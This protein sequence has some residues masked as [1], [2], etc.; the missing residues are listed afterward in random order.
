MKKLGRR[1]QKKKPLSQRGGEESRCQHSTMKDA[2]VHATLRIKE[3]EKQRAQELEALCWMALCPE[4]HN[5]FGRNNEKGE[6]SVSTA[7][8]PRAVCFFVLLWL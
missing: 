3:L 5:S 1:R 4:R 7:R 6:L 2:E 8:L